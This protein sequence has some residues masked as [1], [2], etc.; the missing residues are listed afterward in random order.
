LSPGGIDLFP[1]LLL[2]LSMQPRTLI[3]FSKLGWLPRGV[4]NRRYFEELKS[5]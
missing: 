2:G 1:R 3:L 4:A 5:V